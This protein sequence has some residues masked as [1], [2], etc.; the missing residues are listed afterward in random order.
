MA[1][2]KKIAAPQL[3]EKPAEGMVRLF[4]Q[5]VGFQ[6]FTE[7]HAKALL[8]YQA[9]KGHAHWAPAADAPAETA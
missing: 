4:S 6:D 3:P 2:A 7:A 1:T 8:K 9:E 5:D